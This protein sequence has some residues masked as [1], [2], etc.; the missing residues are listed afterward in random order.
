MTYPL[1]F[2]F[3]RSLIENPV[4]NTIFYF[5]DSEAKKTITPRKEH[6]YKIL[7]QETNQSKKKSKIF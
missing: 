2:F 6:S 4:E 1:S 3:F 5:E 7:C